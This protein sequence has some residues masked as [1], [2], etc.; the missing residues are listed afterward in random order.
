[1]EPMLEERRVCTV[2]QHDYPQR[3]VLHSFQGM[4]I[5]T[6][7]CNINYSTELLLAT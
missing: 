2:A 6:C 7:N 3:L 4:E 5:G 1:M